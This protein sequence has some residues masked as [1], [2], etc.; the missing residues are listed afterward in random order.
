MKRKI[1]IERRGPAA[2]GRCSEH[3]PP[4]PL[5]LLTIKDSAIYCKVSTQT[6]RRA[7][8]SGHLQIYRA[9]KQIRIDEAD[10]LKYLSE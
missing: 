7:I 1:K 8:K 6:I 9:G 4:P 5:N 10:L 3:T 2:S